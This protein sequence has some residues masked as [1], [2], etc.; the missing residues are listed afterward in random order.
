MEWV[1]REL[2]AYLPGWK[3]YFRLALGTSAF[4][5]LDQWLRR[6]LR[7]MQLNQWKRGPTVYR[8]LRR[9]GASGSLATYVARRAR[10]WWHCSLRLSRLL[11]VAYFDN[12]G[13]PR[14]S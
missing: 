10:R 9:L 14:L 8:A 4:R 1:V 12:L 3:N 5:R 13:V 7:A 11:D 6:R 2:K